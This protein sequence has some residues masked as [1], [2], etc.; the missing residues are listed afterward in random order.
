MHAYRRIHLH[1]VTVASYCHYNLPY[2]YMHRETLVGAIANFG[3]FMI[4]AKSSDASTLQ[5]FPLY[6]SC[7]GI[8]FKIVSNTSLGLNK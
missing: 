2:S 6:G 3:K 4:I 1:L 8:H 5:S 7:L